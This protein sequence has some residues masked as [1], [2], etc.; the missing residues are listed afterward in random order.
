MVSTIQEFILKNLKQSNCR[1][2]FPRQNNPWFSRITSFLKIWYGAVRKKVQ[3]KIKFIDKV[4]FL[5]CKFF[6]WKIIFPFSNDSFN[7]NIGNFKREITFFIP[8]PNFRESTTLRDHTT[9]SFFVEFPPFRN[10]YMNFISWG[11]GYSYCR[12]KSKTLFFICFRWSFMEKS[13]AQATYL[14]FEEFCLPDIFP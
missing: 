13:S 6:S 1:E 10:V 4:I 9:L 8:R 12:T 11:S 5:C 3:A 14:L 7:N 2:S